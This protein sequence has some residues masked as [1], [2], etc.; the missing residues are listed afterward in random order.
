MTTAAGTGPRPV[1]RQLLRGIGFFAGLAAAGFGILM[2]VTLVQWVRGVDDAALIP[3]WRRITALAIVAVLVAGS[4]L[5]WRRLRAWA[6]RPR[7]LVPMAG[8][9]LV[10]ALVPAVW[11]PA[12]AEDLAGSSCVPLANAWRPIVT[13]SAADMAFFESGRRSGPPSTVRDHASLLAYTAVLRARQQTPAY[14]RASHYITW[15]VT[16]GRCAPRSRTALEWSA[17]GLGLGA[18]AITLAVRRRR[19][20]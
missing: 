13:A 2:L 9:V 15:V 5:T 18:A 11:L 19:L 6:D 14:Q 17:A 3:A 1:G 20:T 7:W 16:G 8:L 10:A 4:I 12:P